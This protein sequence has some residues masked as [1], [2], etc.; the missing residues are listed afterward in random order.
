MSQPQRTAGAREARWHIASHLVVALAILASMASCRTVGRAIGNADAN[1]QSSIHWVVVPEMDPVDPTGKSV[2]V[3]FRNIA[4]AYEYDFLRSELERAVEERGYEVTRSPGEATFYV[5]AVLRFF[6]KNPNV[7]NGQ[8]LLSAA[9]G[10][11]AGAA[12]WQLAGAVSDSHVVRGATAVSLGAVAS[13]SIKNR[14]AVVE[15]NLLLDVAIGER[16]AQA[17]ETSLRNESVGKRSDTTAQNTGY[18]L[19]GGAD[20][21]SQSRE[22]RVATTSDFF[23]H[24]AR[25]LAVARQIGMKREEA[26]AELSR[27]IGAAL[28]DLMP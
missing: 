14:M 9:G 20:R 6:E 24:E 28:T 11:A 15:W 8:T 7:D 26:V 4:G 12:G 18:Q 16:M 22:Q 19:S 27:K 3:R 13:S 1:A 2:Y 25:L 21:R 5:D 10:V 17:V 23:R